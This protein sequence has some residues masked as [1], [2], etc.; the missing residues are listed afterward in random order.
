MKSIE[1]PCDKE[2]AFNVFVQDMGSWWPLG[3]FTI[4][5]MGGSP[6]TGLRVESKVGGEIV[7]LGPDGAEHFWGRFLEY[8]PHDFLSMDFHI[9]RPDMPRGDGSLVE[10]RFTEIDAARTHVELTQSKWE[11]FGDMAQAVYGGYG[12]GWDMIFGEAYRAACGA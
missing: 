1:V 5:A 7:E 8:D 11:V 9:T 6:A 4:S 10:V 2:T 3:K 12:H